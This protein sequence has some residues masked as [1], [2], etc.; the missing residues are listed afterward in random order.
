MADQAY[1]HH[2]LPNDHQTL[3]G[4]RRTRKAGESHSVG[5]HVGQLVGIGSAG[6]HRVGGGQSVQV[7]AALD[8]FRP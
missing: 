4:Q 1:G 6:Q 5:E 2:L 8:E 7:Q 3:F